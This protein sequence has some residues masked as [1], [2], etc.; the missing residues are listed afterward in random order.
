MNPGEVLGML[1]SQLP[2]GITVRLWKATSWVVYLFPDLQIGKFIFCVS[3]VNF[4]FL[5]YLFISQLNHLYGTLLSF[6]LYPKSNVL[7]ETNPQIDFFFPLVCSYRFVRS[8][9]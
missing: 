7:A 2:D 9:G 5:L 3:F 4:I 8:V 6:I 1:S